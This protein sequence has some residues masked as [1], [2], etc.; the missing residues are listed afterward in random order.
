MTLYNYCCFMLC[1]FAWRVILVFVFVFFAIKTIELWMSTGCGAP[2]GRRR[3]SVSP[4]VGRSEAPS[5]W[6]LSAQSA[7]KRNLG[8]LNPSWTRGLLFNEC[9]PLTR[10]RP[11]LREWR[12]YA[13]KWSAARKWFQPRER[14]QP[15][16]A[17]LY[18]LETCVRQ[19]S[20]ISH[21]SQ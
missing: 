13:E 4:A 8:G 6:E 19:Q 12:C 1:V 2:R 18:C 10:G 9:V 3:G 20:L 17:R 7:L 11:L 16:K 21:T 5:P 14:A 15:V